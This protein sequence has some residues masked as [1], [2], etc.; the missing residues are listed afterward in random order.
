LHPCLA[1]KVRKDNSISTSQT[2]N[3][4]N[5]SIQGRG[6]V[7]QVQNKVTNETQKEKR[8]DLIKMALSKMAKNNQMCQLF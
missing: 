3:F 1:A 7:Q 8:T 5:T 4:H 2:I 6:L